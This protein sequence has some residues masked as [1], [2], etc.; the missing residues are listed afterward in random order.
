MGRLP[1]ESTRDRIVGA[2]ARLVSTQGIGAATTKAI[3][4]EARCAEGN[5]Y[6]HFPSKFGL[7]VEVMRRRFPEFFS[8]MMS[9]PERA[10]TGRVEDT[11]RDVVTAALSFYRDI[12]PMA[13]G[14]LADADLRKEQQEFYQRHGVGPKKAFDSLTAYVRAEQRGGRMSRKVKPDAVARM[15]LGACLAEAFITHLSGDEV[16]PKQDERIARDIAQALLRTVDPN[17]EER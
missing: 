13:A 15:A 7:F 2:A 9:L 11:I 3:A 6:R 4:H 14:T 8:M 17:E 12:I 1:A 5:I 10:G 16:T